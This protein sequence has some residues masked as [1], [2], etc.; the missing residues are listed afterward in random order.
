MATGYDF[1]DLTFAEM[2]DLLVNN[3]RST[4]H[5][6]VVAFDGGMLTLESGALER[7]RMSTR[8]EFDNLLTEAR[9]VVPDSG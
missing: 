6:A 4:V 8:A 3:I 2:P 1:A 7:S 5:P 9:V